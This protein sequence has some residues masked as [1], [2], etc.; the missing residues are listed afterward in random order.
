MQAKAGGGGDHHASHARV[1]PRFFEV[2]SSKVATSFGCGHLRRN[3][4]R[5]LQI[6]LERDED[7]HFGKRWPPSQ[8]E[9]AILATFGSWH[10]PLPSPFEVAFLDFDLQ[11][12]SGAAQRSLGYAFRFG[13]CFDVVDRPGA[14]RQ[15][16]G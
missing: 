4:R 14:A 1:R 13:S 11:P 15:I 3:P 6:E 7:G 10:A 5:G 9:V 16:V 2:A 8:N 12:L